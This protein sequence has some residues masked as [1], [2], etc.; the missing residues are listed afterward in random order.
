MCARQRA[1]SCRNFFIYL[2]SSFKQFCSN[3]K[4]TQIHVGKVESMKSK[5]AEL[6]SYV[7]KPQKLIIIRGKLR[8][9]LKAILRN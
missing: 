4:N 2:I 7:C 1:N 9:T 8:K 3:L 5:L 6:P